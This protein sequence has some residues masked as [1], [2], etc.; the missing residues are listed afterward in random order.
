MRKSFEAPSWIVPRELSRFADIALHDMT[1][2]WDG[3]RGMTISIPGF[4]ESKTFAMS[5]TKVK[6]DKHSPNECRPYERR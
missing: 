1:L 5:G 2:T 6:P 4:T 3:I